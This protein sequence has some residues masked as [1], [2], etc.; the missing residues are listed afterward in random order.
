MRSQCECSWTLAGCDRTIVDQELVDPAKVDQT[1]R[2]QVLCVHGHVE[3]YP[4]ARVQLRIREEQE[5]QLVL[6][7]QCQELVM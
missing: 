3:F 4:T 1:K 7:Q 6:P 5:E 2:A